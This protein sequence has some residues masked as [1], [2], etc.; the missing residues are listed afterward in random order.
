ML[1]KSLSLSI[2]L[3]YL[4]V[5]FFWSCSKEEEKTSGETKIADEPGIKTTRRTSMAGK[6]VLVVN[7][8]HKGYAW[9]D[10]IEAAI[11]A[12]LKE[13]PEIEFEFHRMDT[14]RNSTE[15]LKKAAALEA[16]NNMESWKPDVVIVSDDNA[17][18]YLI[19]PYYKNADLPVVF[20]GVN[21]D[22]AHY[23]YPFENATGMV[24]IAL[25][26]ELIKTLR[27]YSKGNR[28]GL[29]GPDT[30]SAIQDA[31]YYKGIS[32]IEFTEEKYVNDFGEWKAAYIQFQKN[33]DI[34][35]LPAWQGTKEWDEK[36][37]ADFI[38]ANT[39][40]PSGAEVLFMAKYV[41]ATF[42]KDPVEQG[43]WAANTALEILSGKKPGEIPIA[44]NK[45]ARIVLNMK[46]AKK[47]DI[48]FPVEFLERA[49]FVGEECCQ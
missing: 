31:N 43:E 16:K 44:I 24:E 41:L 6:R 21:W 11:S 23:G 38:L 22:A 15:A 42:A 35:I 18:K 32:G 33:V 19:V 48:K 30:T 49:A 36:E 1:K 39:E 26:D 10:G 29:L 28:V 2:L 34:L 37:A 8:Y 9:S 5:A 47:L 27:T 40:I 12:K 3:L 20:C 17:S 4:C 25:M 7:S 46:I 45:K 14:K 13:H